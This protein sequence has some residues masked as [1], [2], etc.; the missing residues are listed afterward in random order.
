[1]PAQDSEKSTLYCSFCGKSQYEVKKLIAGP[2][3]FICDGCTELCA[4]ICR[5]EGI[6]G[7]LPKELRPEDLANIRNLHIKSI[8][9]LLRLGGLDLNENFWDGESLLAALVRGLYM[10]SSEEG[11]AE[12][13]ARRMEDLERQIAQIEQDGEKAKQP[14]QKEL[15]RLKA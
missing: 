6:L 10:S 11:K 12:L 9:D 15:A 7:V 1:M 2:T 13:R 4:D 3:V 5:Q 8:P 14:L